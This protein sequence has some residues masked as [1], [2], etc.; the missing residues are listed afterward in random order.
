[1]LCTAEINIPATKVLSLESE[2]RM[3]PSRF[4]GS[5]YLCQQDYLEDYLFLAYS[6]RCLAPARVT[7]LLI[8][9]VVNQS[10]LAL[11]AVLANFPVERGC[12]L[13]TQHVG[14]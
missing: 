11:Q 1:M 3:S 9:A 7:L 8:I 6:S 13:L 10:I 5:S 2:G 4:S 14:A 12:N